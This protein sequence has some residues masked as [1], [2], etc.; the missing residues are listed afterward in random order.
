MK[1]IFLS[2]LFT[3]AS[4][5]FKDYA[6]DS[7]AGKRVAF[8]PTAARHETI[9]FYVKAGKKVLEQ[10]GMIVDELDV[11]ETS[12]DDISRILSSADVVYISGGNTFFL[13]QELRKSGAGQMIIDHI[14][15]GKMYIGESAGSAILAPDIGYLKAMD[16]CRAAPELTDYAS[17]SALDFYPL[18]HYKSFPFQKVCDKIIR[19][20]GTVLPLVPFGNKQAVLVDDVSHHIIP[21]NKT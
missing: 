16:D 6:W 10:A 18:P 7:F 4:V 19:D 5:L 3:E 21:G 9:N 13:L 15:A 12:H 1:R 8:I 14:A 17:L 11:S 20:Y 2:S